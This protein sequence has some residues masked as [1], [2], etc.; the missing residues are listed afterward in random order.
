MDEEQLAFLTTHYY[1][2]Q[3]LRLVPIF[4]TFIAGRWINF[5]N[6]NI[7][8]TVVWIGICIGWFWLLNTYYKKHYG[9]VKSNTKV[10][11]KYIWFVLLSLWPL[12]LYQRFTGHVS[13]FDLLL[14]FTPCYLLAE[15]LAAFSPISRR[16]AYIILAVII[17]TAIL[18]DIFTKAPGHQFFHALEFVIFGSALLT[19]AIFDHI[20][21][22]R[23]FRTTRYEINI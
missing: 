17:Q 12:F 9:R 5:G 8:F 10:D 14:Q 6:A 22:A 21:L 18:M 3:S 13:S 11:K 4:I 16:Y 7:F 20:L 2:L 19:L 15:G 1:Q 23:L